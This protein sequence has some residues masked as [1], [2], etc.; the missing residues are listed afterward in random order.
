MV[1]EILL[2]CTSQHTLPKGPPSSEWL[3]A[4]I[5]L[6]NWSSADLHWSSIPMQG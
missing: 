2:P 3:W 1:I 4:E 6:S 5:R